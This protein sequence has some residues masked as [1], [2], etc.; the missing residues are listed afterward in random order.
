M[1]ALSETRS[2]ISK[3]ARSIR[4]SGQGG[5][6]PGETDGPTGLSRRRQRRTH[7]FAILGV[8]V[9]GLTALVGAGVL[10][11]LRVNLTPSEPLGLWRIVSLDR[12]VAVGDLVFV[13]PPPGVVSAF[14]LARGYF[15]RGT[16]PGGV[17]PLIKTVAAIAGA[18][19]VVKT[20]V[21]ID[22][23]PL[24]NSRLSPKDGQD[25]ALAPWAGGILPDGQL[26]LHSTFQGS[27]DSR[28][29][30]PVPDAGLLGL[31]RP[32]LTLSLT[33]DNAP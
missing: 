3:V 31:A 17:A 25:R 10:A 32:V 2:I 29:L 1:T 4:S 23:I 20:A 5:N 15:R 11:G 24:P 16:C 9:A 30:G 26:F 27:Y 6:H 28:Y 22:G 21:K 14:G 33:G 12:P 7:A 19:I 18:S 8:G 13:C